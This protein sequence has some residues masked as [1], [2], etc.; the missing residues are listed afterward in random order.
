MQHLHTRPAPGALASD[1]RLLPVG[2]D[3]W[4]VVD[5]TGLALGHLAV[6]ST[7]G[8]VRWHAR[9]FHVPSRAFRDIGS[10]WTPA[11]AVECLRFSR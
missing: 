8:G 6:T 3:L 7:A 5:R 1:L 2:D 4:R 10:F 9:R 11:E